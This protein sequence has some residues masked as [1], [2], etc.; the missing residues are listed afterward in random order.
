MLNLLKD[1]IH[2]YDIFFQG[3]A[4]E[5]IASLNTVLLDENEKI[6]AKLFKYEYLR[7]RYIRIHVKIR[8]IL[9]QYTQINPVILKS[10]YGKPYLKDFPALEFNLSHSESKAIFAITANEPIGVDIEYKNNNI[11]FRDLA[12]SYFSPA[13]IK[14][15]EFAKNFHEEFLKLWTRKEAYLKMKGIGLSECLLKKDIPKCYTVYDFVYDENYMASLVV[16]NAG[17]KLCMYNIAKCN[18]ETII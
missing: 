1:N 15:L 8:E 16:K 5:S 4:E 17:K 3:G 12:K 9:M 14:S 10:N 6:R 18:I 7:E 2:V 11:D 13:E